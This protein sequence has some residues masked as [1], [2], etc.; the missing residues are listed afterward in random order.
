MPSVACRAMNAAVQKALFEQNRDHPLGDSKYGT[1]DNT[2]KGREAF[3]V[4]FRP[5]TFSIP[6]IGDDSRVALQLFHEWAVEFGPNSPYNLIGAKPQ[7][8][9][10]QDAAGTTHPL[11]YRNW[12]DD[13]FDEQK[14]PINPINNKRLKLIDDTMNKEAG[15]RAFAIRAR[16]GEFEPILLPHYHEMS[17]G[18]DNMFI[19]LTK[20]CAGIR[21]NSSILADKSLLAIVPLDYTEDGR[22]N[23]AHVFRTPLFF[24]VK[25]KPSRRIEV[26]IV[27][28][29]DRFINNNFKEIA[30]QLL[31]R[32][33]P[34]HLGNGED[35]FPF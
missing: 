13:R 9:S 25:G 6:E 8:F 19:Y 15:L 26:S 27:G 32:K 28:K 30:V 14:G 24:P 34:V 20:I 16:A 33:G 35:T 7:G 5:V 18:V 29:Y 2:D 12:D 1:D 22:R 11:Q 3:L 31:V 21:P 23:T 17:D 4:T 10:M